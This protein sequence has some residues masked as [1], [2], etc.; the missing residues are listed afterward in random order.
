MAEQMTETPTT[1]T[2]GT[3]AST[4]AATTLLTSMEPAAIPQQQAAA[5]SEG[6]TK[7]AEGEKPAGAPEKYE[8][9]A[10]EGKSYDPAVLN[11]YS[12][13]AKTANLTQ[14]TAQKLLESMAPQLA[15]RQAE[16][17][18]AIQSQW[19]EA[20]KVDKEFGGE[21]LA[22]NLAVAKTAVDRFASPEMKKL[23]QDTGLGNNP[24]VIRTFLKIGKGMSQD[25]F[26]TGGKPNGETRD[27]GKIL[28]DKS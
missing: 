5:R 22:E 21:K 12:E 25:G 11:A 14:E 24:E 13:A 10:P 4:A 19:T 1:P 9:T 23:L 18:A 26:V 17:V 8:F 20:S 6:E 15:T 16:Q 7:P 28:Y 3:P 2:E 27:L